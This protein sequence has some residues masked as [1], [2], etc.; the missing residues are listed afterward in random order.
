MQDIS[1]RFPYLITAPT[2]C[3]IILSVLTWSLDIDLRGCWIKFL[4][5]C[6]PIF[7][8]LNWSYL[9]LHTFIGSQ[10]FEFQCGYFSLIYSEFLL[11]IVYFF[12]QSGNMKEFKGQNF[13]KLLKT[14]LEYGVPFT[15]PLFPPNNSSL[16]YS[17][18]KNSHANIV[19]KRPGVSHLFHFMSYWFYWIVSIL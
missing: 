4:F 18:N 11:M 1:S 5:G 12:T 2:Y 14:Q 9:N 7:F 6:S 8:A 15:D 19:W 17:N 13:E 16:F 10:P 3:L